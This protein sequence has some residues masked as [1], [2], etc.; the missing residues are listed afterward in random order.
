MVERTACWIFVSLVVAAASAACSGKSASTSTPIAECAGG[1]RSTPSIP[2]GDGGSAGASDAARASAGAANEGGD[3]GEAGERG[4]DS[5]ILQVHAT[6]RVTITANLDANVRL[7]NAPFAIGDPANT[8]NFSTTISVYSAS[9]DAHAITVYFAKNAD[10]AW[11]YYAVASGQDLVPYSLD[12]R[13]IGSG[14]LTFTSNG[15]LQAQT[16][17]QDGLVTF[18]G[19]SFPQHIAFD[20][21]TPLARGGTGLDGATQFA[22][23]CNVSSQ[24]QDGYGSGL[25]GTGALCNADSDCSSKDCYEH[26]CFCGPGCGCRQK[27]DCSS[28]R[29]V[30][31]DGACVLGD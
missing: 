12:N 25:G 29:D 14:H 23:P 10:N 11:D 2:S 26:T 3:G 22:S 9:G 19:D 15:A 1:E 18:E 17:V 27:W 13:L 21:G 20:F 8:S 6:G 24:S 7:S 4:G 16:T 31:V 5:P 30:C 28:A